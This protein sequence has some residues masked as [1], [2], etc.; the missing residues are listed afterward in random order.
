MSKLYV[1]L[2]SQQLLH[3]PFMTIPS[4]L[5][6]RQGLLYWDGLA[7][8]ADER[9]V[10]ALCLLVPDIAFLIREGLLSPL[11]PDCLFVPPIL[12][13]QT[14][15]DRERAALMET[16]LA[17]AI[18]TS[19]T[20]EAIRAWLAD[21]V[22]ILQSQVKATEE[23][24]TLEEAVR[25]HL[26]EVADLGLHGK[27]QTRLAKR[28]NVSVDEARRHAVLRNALHWGLLARDY[29]AFEAERYVPS[30]DAMA[31]GQ[32]L[33]SSSAQTSSA[34]VLGLV[35]SNAFPMPAHDTRI[36][37]IVRF[38]ER[39]W[40]RYARFRLL[41]DELALEVA[42]ASDEAAVL[43]CLRRFMHDMDIQRHE[44]ASKLRRRRLKAVFNKVDVVLKTESS[45]FVE[46]IGGMAFASEIPVWW[47][48]VGIGAPL[49]L[50]ITKHAIR[51]RNAI[52]DALDTSPVAYLHGAKQRGLLMEAFPI[53]RL[54][55]TLQKKVS[56]HGTNRVSKGGC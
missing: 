16:P 22:T 43:R 50:E 33:Y 32:L 37:D 51:E 48:A 5:W 40:E 13:A 20:G 46:A 12:D 11:K 27:V 1:D 44:L 23:G 36:E 25:K 18:Q 54:F 24:I 56:R 10:D 14:E 9:W 19:P 2:T 8:F 45:P 34:P 15:R 7:L 28:L 29:S 31:I 35:L 39:H 38:K 21:S 6:L 42:S 30:T 41:I 17:K 26:E 47:K 52:A 4:G 53:R 55:R 49:V 3:F